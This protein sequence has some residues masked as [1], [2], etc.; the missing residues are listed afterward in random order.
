MEVCEPPHHWLVRTTDADDPSE[1]ALE[2]TLT[3]DG[4]HTI[5]VVEER[6]MPLD[7]LAADGAGVQVHA[8]DLAAHV[9]G[10][11]RRNMQPRRAELLPSTGRWSRRTRSAP[12]PSRAG[13]PAPCL[14]AG[15]A[16]AAG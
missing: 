12:A 14:S 5:L 10:R 13:P 9:A 11:D 15:S 16:T 6:G 2:A 7:Q 1:H 3:A 8:E 4:D